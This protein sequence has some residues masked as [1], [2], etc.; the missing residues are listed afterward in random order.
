MNQF[1]DYVTEMQKKL[2]KM[3]MKLVLTVMQIHYQNQL[4]FKIVIAIFVLV[5]DIGCIKIM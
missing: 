3:V 2:K 5:V 1:V 4:H